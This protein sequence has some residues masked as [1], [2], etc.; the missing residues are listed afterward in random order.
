MHTLLQKF[1]GDLRPIT[2][3]DAGNLQARNEMQRREEYIEILEA[4]IGRYHPALVEVV[5]ECFHND[6]DQR[7]TT[8]NLLARL[9]G[10]REEVEGGCG[11]GVVRLD[12]FKMKLLQEMKIL[13][14]R[15]EELTR[16][17]VLFRQQSWYQLCII[18]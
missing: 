17:Q 15:I 18:V 2:F 16:E 1:P 11:G 12:L 8:D 3:F 7:P 5:K 14:R 9:Q 4:H 10:M 13:N 6:P